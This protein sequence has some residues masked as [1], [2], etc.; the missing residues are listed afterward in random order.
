MRILHVT[1]KY[2]NAIGGDSI[3]VFNLE[4]EQAKTGHKVFILTTNSYEIITKDNVCKFGLKDTAHSW[5]KITL[6]RIVSLVLFS[7][8]SLWIIKKIRPDIIHSHSA[9]LGFIISIWAR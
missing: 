1:K 3:C 7:I 5:D 4:K 8:E 2:P 6:R 9:D